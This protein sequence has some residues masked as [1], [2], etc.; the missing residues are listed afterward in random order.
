MQYPSSVLHSLTD[1]LRMENRCHQKEGG[2]F[3]IQFVKATYHRER[4]ERKKEGLMGVWEDEL[5]KLFKRLIF[6]NIK[7]NVIWRK[8]LQPFEIA[9]VLIDYDDSCRGEYL[10]F[11][12]WIIQ[13]TT[14]CVLV[15]EVLVIKHPFKS[16]KLC[17]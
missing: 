5:L 10:N 8:K 13:T 9:C 6:N 1:S 12:S 15:V 3:W 16:T 17:R 11:R 2:T 14:T 4:R 7:G